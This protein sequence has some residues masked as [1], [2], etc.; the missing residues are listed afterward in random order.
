MLNQK[1]TYLVEAADHAARLHAVQ[2]ALMRQEAT[3]LAMYPCCGL[4]QHDASCLQQ[5]GVVGAD[6]VSALSL[7]CWAL[8]LIDE[9]LVEA[10]L[11]SPCNEACKFKC[12]LFASSRD[13][14]MRMR[15]C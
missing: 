1:C 15:M 12:M 13:V 2:L 9:V 11:P 5:V 10:V 14:Q 7:L 8:F 6:G 4:D 3:V